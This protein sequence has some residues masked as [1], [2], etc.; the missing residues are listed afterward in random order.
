MKYFSQLKST[1]VTC[2]VASLV[3]IVPILVLAQ[4]GPQPTP[5]P[6]TGNGLSYAIR[7]PLNFE[8]F[9]DLFNAILTVLM[10]VLTPIVVMFIIFSGFKYVTAQGNPA[11]VQEATQSLTYA[12]IGGVLIV[13]ALAISRI[14]KGFVDAFAA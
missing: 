2:L 5:V 13:G 6:A 8:S 11:K 10:V 9:P 14:I 7:N 3:Y 12:I 1:G 4:G